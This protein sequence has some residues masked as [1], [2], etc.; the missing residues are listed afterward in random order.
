MWIA[1]IWLYL[2]PRRATTWVGPAALW[3]FIL[4]ATAMWLSGPWSPPP[5]SARAIGW[6]ALIGWITIPWTA[7]A[8]RYYVLRAG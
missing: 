3:S 6:L 7:L 1:G 2:G 5:P 4:V 8:D